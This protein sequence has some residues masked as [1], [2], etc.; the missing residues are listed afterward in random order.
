MNASEPTP[1][2]LYIHWPWCRKKCPYCDFNSHVNQ[3]A[4]AE[5]YLAALLR[6]METSAQTVAPGRLVSVFFGGGTPSLMAP[7]YVAALVDKA[8]DLFGFAPDIEITLEANPTSAEAAKFQAFA[9]AG[10]NRFSIGMQSPEAADLAFLGREHSADEATDAVKDALKATPNV[11]LD[12]I[13]GLPNQ[14]LDTW[15]ANLKGLALLG[16]PH[17]SCYQ[18]T[19]EKN[20][21]FYADMNKGRLTPAPDD[22]QATFYHETNTVLTEAGF[23]QYEVSNYARGGAVCHHNKHIWQY[24]SYIG[25][26]AGAHGRTRQGAGTLLATRN[27]KMPEKYIDMVRQNGHGHYEA[28]PIEAEEQ[29]TEALLLGLR[30]AEG[31]PLERLEALTGNP[32]HTHLE[33]DGI[34]LMATNGL[35]VPEVDTTLKATPQGLA[36]LEG[37]LGYIV[38]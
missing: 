30:L 37:V 31:L 4:P 28:Q 35:L 34:A 20:T 21:R 24:G 36:M 26:G 33:K 2:A 29:A 7:E 5:D 9:A 11:S 18:L 27:Y 22:A 8:H 10:V 3:G 14:D 12:L 16:T 32:W 1:H 25:I 19:I 13:Y 6:E 17:I 15:Q 23:E 38:K